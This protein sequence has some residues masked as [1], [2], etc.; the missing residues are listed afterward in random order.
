MCAATFGHDKCVHLLM[1]VGCDLK[2]CETYKVVQKRL[3][4][5]NEIRNVVT[6]VLQ[7]ERHFP[8]VTSEEVADFLLPRY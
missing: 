6:E 8:E 1:N 7:N 4:Y 2:K 3:Q 5:Q